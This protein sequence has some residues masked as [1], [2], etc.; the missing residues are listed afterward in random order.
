MPLAQIYLKL[1]DF[2][3]SVEALRPLQTRFSS[4]DADAQ[5]TI[6]RAF[7]LAGD[8]D[9]AARLLNEP[10]AISAA[11]HQALLGLKD[12]VAAKP[13]QA[14][15]E[16]QRVLAINPSDAWAGYL[17]GKA[18]LAAGEDTRAMTAWSEVVKAQSPPPQAVIGL[19]ALMAHAGSADAADAMLDRVQGADRK[20][21]AY[22]EAAALI[23]RQ[24]KHATMEKI[25]SGYASY[26]AGDPWQAESIWR[27]ALN[28]ASDDLAR[29]IY[30]ALSNSAFRR[31][32]AEAALQYAGEAARRW[33]NDP[34]ALRQ[35]AETLL[36]QSQLKE[37]I[38][39]AQ[40]FQAIAPA[41]RQA[42]A[43]ELLSRIALDAVKPD[44]LQSS[45]RQDRT[46]APSDPMPLLHLAEWQGQQG[47]DPANL[48][49]TLAL[50]QDAR[51]I[52]PDNAEAAARAGVILADLKRN[53][54]A[55]STLLHALTLNPRVMDGTP[56]ALLLQLYQRSEETREGRFEAQWY[57]RVRALKETWP[58]LLKTMRQPNASSS[59]WKAL[60]EM[61]L[62]R[63]E[64]WI[65]LCAFTRRVKLAPSD[66]VARA[67]LA[68]AQKR[69]GWFDEAL[70]SMIKAHSLQHKAE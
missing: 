29:E 15:S 49:K 42:Q 24:R 11:D 17:L 50:Y 69:L 47:R 4:L 70:E 6:V 57:Q 62:R 23:A 20:L 3:K 19:A 18:R 55:I 9:S 46:L 22:W 64:N 63:H 13:A 34:E 32:D 58:T 16:L 26:N 44:L 66:P 56:N 68:M 31:A 28:N 33:S 36:A 21:P 39:A 54:E 25:A 59:D 12:L 67:E 37:A 1:G 60:G 65:A 8:P 41:N 51:T 48:E 2:Q 14:V 5:Q 38:A 7:L 10:G 53:T 40:H 43:A 52:A 30:S 61:A 45:A 35:Y 27:A